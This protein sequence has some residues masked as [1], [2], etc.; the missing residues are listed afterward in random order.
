MLIF[1]L[2]K[3]LTRLLL[4]KDIASINNLLSLSETLVFIFHTVFAQLFGKI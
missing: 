4:F 2:F 1:L 3:P